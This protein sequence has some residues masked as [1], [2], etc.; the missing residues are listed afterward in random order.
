[1][2]E[3]LQ[4]ESLI[5]QFPAMRGKINEDHADEVFR[6]FHDLGYH[7]YSIGLSQLQH[8]TTIKGQTNR[9]FLFL[10]RKLSHNT[11]SYDAI[12]SELIQVN[13]VT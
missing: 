12:E 1:M 4:Y 13:G 5:K 10:S 8:I 11:V 6:L 9:N 7:G 2:I 3:I